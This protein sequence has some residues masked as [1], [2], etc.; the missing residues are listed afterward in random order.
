MVIIGQTGMY[1]VYPSYAPMRDRVRFVG[2]R[3]Q[4]VAI[5]EHGCRMN[6]RCEV[7]GE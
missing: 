1:I 7:G 6:A 2:P 4:S 3:A 5:I